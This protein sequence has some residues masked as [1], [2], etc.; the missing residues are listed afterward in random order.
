M[1]A[2]YLYFFVT[3]KSAQDPAKFNKAF[4]ADEE[5]QV[6]RSISNPR[7]HGLTNLRDEVY[8][9]I[10]T[11]KRVVFKDPLQIAYFV[12]ATSKLTMLSFVYDFLDVYFPR[13]AY[14]I[15]CTDTDS[16]YFAYA[17]ND[18]NDFED[19]VKPQL[20]EQY[21]RNRGRFLPSQA[22]DN[23]VCFD[24]YVTCKMNKTPW[25]QPPCCFKTELYHNRTPGLFKTEY[26]GDEICF[27]APKTYCCES[28]GG[29]QKV[30]C[31]GV[32]KKINPL[33]MEDFLRVLQEGTRHT[34]LNRG[35]RYID[36]KMRTY[37]QLKCGLSP[38]FIKRRVLEDGIH[39]E[40]LD[41]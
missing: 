11:P 34:V 24:H 6:C 40:P 23:N 33:K 21:F 14:E 32:N 35:F 26:E 31:K 12:Y 27:L 15:C 20:R 41:I 8:E 18:T 39:T 28:A 13:T 4:L 30:S 2:G 36:G 38:I 17:A 10:H 5:K 19:W 22:C 25:V 37:A 29:N 1:G 7:F 3:G 16:L 9:V